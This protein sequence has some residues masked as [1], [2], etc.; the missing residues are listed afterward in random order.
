M[1][2]IVVNNICA[3]LHRAV[4]WAGVVLIVYFGL[5]KTIESAAGQST[6]INYIAQIAAGF[7]LNEWAA[8]AIGG[9]GTIYGLLQRKLRKDT[10]ERLTK[11]I[12]TL[13]ENQDPERSSSKLTPRGET[14]V[15][16]DV[17]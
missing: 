17:T 10:I 9:A 8:Y 7:S 2:F 5:Y 3:V 4:P 14:P 13:E 11:R 12:K 16:E 15:E 1:V 6:T